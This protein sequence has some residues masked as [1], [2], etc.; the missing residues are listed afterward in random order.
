[1]EVPRNDPY[2][3]DGEYTEVPPS[4]PGQTLLDEKLA[5]LTSEGLTLVSYEPLISLSSANLSSK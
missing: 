5:R 2:Y 1:M 4:G 3:A